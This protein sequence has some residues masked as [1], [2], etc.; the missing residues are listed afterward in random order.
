[1]STSKKE[2][3]HRLRFGS[4]KY[5]HGETKRLAPRFRSTLAS[6]VQRRPREAGGTAVVQNTTRQ[7]G[8]L[9]VTASR[10]NS[11]ARRWQRAS[12]APCQ[13]SPTYLWC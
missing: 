7:V 8:P 11:L 6:K 5:H 4:S 10:A 3:G 12:D 1:M 9:A 13:S 2:I